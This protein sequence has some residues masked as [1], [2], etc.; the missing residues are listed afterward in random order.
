MGNGLY[1]LLSVKDVRLGDSLL[2]N[3]EAFSFLERCTAREYRIIDSPFV[4]IY[5]SY[6]RIEGIIH[7]RFIL[8]FSV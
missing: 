3:D 6:R 5:F 8:S 7:F 4:I 1:F 2:A